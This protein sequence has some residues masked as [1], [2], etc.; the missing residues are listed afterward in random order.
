M[1]VPPGLSFPVRSASS[2]IDSAI[3]SL[4][5]PPGF[6]LSDFIQTSARSPNRRLIRMCGVLPMVSRTLAA[7]MP[8]CLLQWGCGQI[9][10]VEAFCK[11]QLGEPP[12]P[13]NDDADCPE[14]TDD[15]I[16]RAH[17]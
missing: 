10:C 16:G 17:V 4:I 14:T 7:F 9:G 13:Q 8:L 12:R 3:R 5:D 6:A 2:I 11:A 1:I 15:E